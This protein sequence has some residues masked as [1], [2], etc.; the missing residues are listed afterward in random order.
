MTTRKAPTAYNVGAHVVAPQ[1][2][3]EPGTR[4]LT[5]INKCYSVSPLIPTQSNMAAAFAIFWVDVMISQD[6]HRFT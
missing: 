4:W 2:G 5:A 3:L 1:P 6:R